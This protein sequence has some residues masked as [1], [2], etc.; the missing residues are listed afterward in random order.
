MALFCSLLSSGYADNMDDCDDEDP[1]VSP[2]TKRCATTRSTTTAMAT[3]MVTIWT[4]ED[5]SRRPIDEEPGDCDDSRPDVYP[6]AFEIE[7]EST[8]TA[9]GLSTTAQIPT[10]MMATDIRKMKATATMRMTPFIR[11]H[12][13]LRRQGQ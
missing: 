6:G 10:M 2:V 4:D 8:T 5:G 11:G 12:P 13:R 3:L 7:M 1:D 9:M